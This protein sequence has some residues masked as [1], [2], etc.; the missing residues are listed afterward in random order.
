MFYLGELGKF[1][2][3]HEAILHKCIQQ[4]TY[5]AFCLFIYLFAYLSIYLFIYCFFNVDNYKTNTVYNK[6]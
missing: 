4:V 5:I 3:V 1:E 2:L 6:K